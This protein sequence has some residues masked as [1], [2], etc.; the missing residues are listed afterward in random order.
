MSAVATDVDRFHPG[1]DSP[2]PLPDQEGCVPVVSEWRSHAVA[3]Q[4][5]PPGTG[6][7]LRGREYTADLRGAHAGAVVVRVRERRV[8]ISVALPGLYGY[9]T[10]VAPLAAIDGSVLLTFCATGPSS[11]GTHVALA[12]PSNVK[13]T[14]NPSTNRIIG[15]RRPRRCRGPGF[16]VAATPL[17]N[18]T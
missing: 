13:T 1:C 5:T 14:P 16:G 15:K 9:G 10:T 7:G 11:R 18:E 2:S 12:A 17:T 6:G 8:E 3:P 4:V